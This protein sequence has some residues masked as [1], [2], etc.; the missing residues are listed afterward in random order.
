MSAKFELR[1]AAELS[2]KLHKKL[3]EDCNVPQNAIGG[4]MR[5]EYIKVRKS[6]ADISKEICK[7]LFM[8]QDLL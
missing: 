5:P 1:Y 3:A 7:Q 8:L 4:K 2:K 6:Q